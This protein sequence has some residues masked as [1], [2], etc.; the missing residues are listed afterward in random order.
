MTP[1]NLTACLEFL[2]ESDKRDTFA[3]FFDR[4]EERVEFIQNEFT[5]FT[6]KRFKVSY[7][8]LK[9]N[10]CRLLFL[11]KNIKDMHFYL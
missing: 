11:Y 1:K 9:V 5:L 7:T 8:D 3:K 10:A 2:E 6:Y 4:I